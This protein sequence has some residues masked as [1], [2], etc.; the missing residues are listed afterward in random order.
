MAYR[1]SYSLFHPDENLDGVTIHHTC[2][3]R[4]C[5]NPDHLQ[6]LSS[7]NNVAEMVERTGYI[8]RIARL[9]ERVAELE[10]QLRKY[11]DQKQS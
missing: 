10:E 6:A 4:L 5:V 3:N 2:A 8:R 1:Y 9:E 7:I 11:E